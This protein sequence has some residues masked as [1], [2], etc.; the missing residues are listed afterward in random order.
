LE[1]SALKWHRLFGISIDNW[2][3]YVEAMQKYL[4]QGKSQSELEADFNDA[5]H[6]QK[7]NEKFVAYLT[8]LKAVANKLTPP[9]SDINLFERV[10]RGLLTE[11][12]TCKLV[13]KDLMDL[14]AKC[15]DY[16]NMKRPRREEQ[17]PTT[18]D[19]FKWL[20]GPRQVA[21]DGNTYKRFL[22]SFQRHQY[23]P[24]N[25]VTG[26][27]DENALQGKSPGYKQ[28][29]RP[30]NRREFNN[31]PSTAQANAQFTEETEA[32]EMVSEEEE[33]EEP[34]ELTRGDSRAVQ[35][36]D[37]EY[38]SMREMELREYAQRMNMS[39]RDFGNYQRNQTCSNCHYRGHTVD[40]CHDAK[41]GIWYEHCRT[42]YRP[43]V[44]SATCTHC[45]TKN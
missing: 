40:Q 13:A 2:G 26:R 19:P 33:Y 4:N 44:T 8:R 38:I 3:D 17:T 21:A 39:Q 23:K 6:N 10:K 41:R 36:D 1:G 5:Q 9:P 12:F 45:Q 30:W 11:Y 27:R 15:G 31:K 16:E 35:A 24:N 22:P 7:P 43:N 42:C 37:E 20:N 18:A 32:V 34:P 28:N 14:M 29:F 25:V